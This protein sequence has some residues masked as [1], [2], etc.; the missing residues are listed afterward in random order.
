MAGSDGGNATL[1][2]T[3][4]RWNSASDV[5]ADVHA[6]KSRIGLQSAREATANGASG[7]ITQTVRARLAPRPA[8]V[9]I[10][11]RGPRTVPAPVALTARQGDPRLQFESRLTDAP[12]APSTRAGCIAQIDS[13]AR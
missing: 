6:P 4:T 12:S 11:A 13:R 3:A 1:V 5:P 2:T 10:A 9:C 8:V 7:Q